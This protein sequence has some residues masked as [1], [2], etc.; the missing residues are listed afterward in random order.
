MD[1]IERVGPAAHEPAPIPR[2]ERLTVREREEQARER[3]RK[4]REQQRRRQAPPED[5]GAR[6]VD[7]RA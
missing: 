6:H 1:R 4:R 7:I 5:P 2:I 3:E